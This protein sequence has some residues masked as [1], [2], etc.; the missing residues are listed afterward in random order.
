MGFNTKVKQTEEELLQLIN[1]KIQM[2]IPHSVL[3]LILENMLLKIENEVNS[4]I[5]SEEENEKLKQGV[6][7]ETLADRK[8]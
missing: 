7:T 1:S 5:Q 6:V 4:I 3:E 2:G 8:E